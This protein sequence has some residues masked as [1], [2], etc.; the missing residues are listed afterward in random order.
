MDHLTGEYSRSA[1]HATYKCQAV[2]LI[3]ARDLQVLTT[4][5]MTMRL[6]SLWIDHSVCTRSGDTD[7]Y[8]VSH[9]TTLLKPQDKAVKYVMIL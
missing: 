2:V 6:T 8:S 4:A 9:D 3:F 1:V 5:S 7:P